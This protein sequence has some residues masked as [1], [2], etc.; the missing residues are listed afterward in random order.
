MIRAF[1]L[2]LLLTCSASSFAARVSMKPPS[3]VTAGTST[4]DGLLSQPYRGTQSAVDVNSTKFSGDWSVPYAGGQISVP[5][6]MAVADVA[7][8]VATNATKL[9]PARLVVGTV[10]VWLAEKGIEYIDGVLKKKQP[11]TSSPPSG[12]QYSWSGAVW[13]GDLATACQQAMSS[14]AYSSATPTPMTGCTHLAA[15]Q[16][17]YKPGYGTGQITGCAATRGWNTANCPSGT[18]VNTDG[19]CQTA[20]SYQ[21]ATDADLR[22]IPGPLPDPVI[23]QLTQAGVSLPVTQ[24][25]FGYLPPVPLGNP[26]KDSTTGG[27]SQDVVS[28]VPNS[29]GTADV[30]TGKRSV[31]PS[32]NPVTDPATGQPKNDTPT[33]DFCAEHPDVLS[34]LK[35]GD[36]P[37]DDPVQVKE[38]QVSI[39]PDSGWGPSNGTCPADLS[40]TTGTGMVIKLSYGPTCRAASI[41]RPIII[42]LGWLSAVLIFMGISRRVQG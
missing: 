33:P 2:A 37:A 32:G 35:V 12:A 18:T 3:N 40:H 6:T 29:D 26:Y 31:D 21:P 36:V 23:K 10:A 4:F 20:P 27:Y 7:V 11:G 19:T 17:T 1:V 14:G 34:C 42:G 16:L 5:S 15:C 41:L 22:A 13:V 9:S 28:V 8:A 30:S 39:S 24:P 25:Q 38:K